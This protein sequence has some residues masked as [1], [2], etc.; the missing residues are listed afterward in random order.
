MCV[1]M[2]I[3]KRVNVFRRIE[4][5]GLIYMYIH[6]LITADGMMREKRNHLRLSEHL[7][8]RI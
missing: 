3:N 1:Y 6:T 8:T 5:F 7:M 2:R 4:M